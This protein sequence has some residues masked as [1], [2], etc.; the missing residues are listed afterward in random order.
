ML[1]GHKAI[2]RVAALG[3]AAQ[4]KGLQ[5]GQRTAHGSGYCDTF[6]RCNQLNFRQGTA[7][8]IMN[9]GGFAGSLLPSL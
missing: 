3:S 1:A 5:V 7:P 9:R 2:G 6:I 8:T 4:N